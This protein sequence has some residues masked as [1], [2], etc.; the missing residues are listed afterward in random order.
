MTSQQDIRRGYET[1]VGTRPYA[2]IERA[3]GDLMT[4]VGANSC[5][6]VMGANAAYEWA[7]GRLED[8][9]VTGRGG[10]GAVDLSLLASEL[11]A[12]VTLLENPEEQPGSL[13]FLRGVQA[14]LA[15][16]CGRS[17]ES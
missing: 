10:R 3:L 6:Y 15:W 9:P 2:D 7:L 16:V 17:L 1:R 11:N 12:A 4:Q 8:P 14:A 13:D 5:Q